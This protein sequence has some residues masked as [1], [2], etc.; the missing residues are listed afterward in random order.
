MQQDKAGTLA[1]DLIGEAIPQTTSEKEIVSW[2]MIT[3]EG[4]RVREELKKDK[5]TLK[6]PSGKVS[7]NF[8]AMA[9]TMSITCR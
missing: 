1:G 5:I 8:N 3:Q 2:D 6:D 4:Q 7:G 9:K